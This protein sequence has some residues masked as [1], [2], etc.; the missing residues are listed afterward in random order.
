MPQQRGKIRAPAT[1]ARMPSYGIAWDRAE[2]LHSRV[3]GHRDQPLRR[4][5]SGRVGDGLGRRRDSVLTN[6]FVVQ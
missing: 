1:Q 5:A 3:S 6:I 4:Y 2:P